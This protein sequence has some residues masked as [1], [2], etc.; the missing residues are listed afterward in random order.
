V[1]F[2]WTF[3]VGYTLASGI[4]FIAA[5]MHHCLYVSRKPWLHRE[6]CQIRAPALFDA[7]N[8]IAA[9]Y[10]RGGV[11]DGVRFVG[12]APVTPAIQPVIPDGD[13]V[14]WIS[15]GLSPL[16]W[17]HAAPFRIRYHP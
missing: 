15:T 7:A 4:V 17:F 13:L 10:F 12:L 6:F 11:G 2:G 1:L 5:S 3:F 14:V 16:V 9:G 8:A